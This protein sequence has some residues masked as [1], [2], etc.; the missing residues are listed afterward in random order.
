MTKPGEMCGNRLVS[1]MD[2]GFHWGDI[3]DLA[4]ELAEEERRVRDMARSY[5][6]ENLL[7]RVIDAYRHGNSGIR[8]DCHVTRHLQNL[9]IVNTDEGT[10]DIH[11]L[12]L[13]RA[14]TGIQAF[15]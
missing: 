12:I 14:Q 4:D 10:H 1:L 6:R 11:A 2:A 5:A 8:A 13:S 15:G 7:P 9:E 3:L